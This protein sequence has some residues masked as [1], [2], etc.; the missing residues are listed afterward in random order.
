MNFIEELRTSEEF[1]RL[2]EAIQAGRL[3]PDNTA[4]AKDAND[5][6]IKNLLGEKLVFHYGYDR[7]LEDPTTEMILYK[8]GLVQ[9]LFDRRY[10]YTEK[11]GKIYANGLC[12]TEAY[13]KARLINAS[14]T[15]AGE[16]AHQKVYRQSDGATH[17]RVEVADTELASPIPL[18]LADSSSYYRKFDT[19]AA[20]QYKNDSNYSGV[21]VK[22]ERAQIM[23]SH[24]LSSFDISYF[25]D[26]ATDTYR[27]YGFSLHGSAAIIAESDKGC[28]YMA[29]E[30]D[31]KHY[32]I[33]VNC[34]DTNAHAFV[35]LNKS[36][37]GATKKIL[38]NQSQ[39]EMPKRLA[40]CIAQRI[41][42]GPDF[43][44][45]PEK[46]KKSASGF[47]MRSLPSP[48]K[49]LS[50]LGEHFFLQPTKNSI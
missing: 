9:L 21:S 42:L 15:H 47:T 50:F 14:T 13:I 23:I 43:L 24:R 49:K 38:W 22:N 41:S 35:I 25:I 17:V 32:F 10:L 37:N 7:I 26:E 3:R 1:R 46:E 20:V 4:Q 44:K 5:A 31:K 8:G 29:T 33:L 16:L 12:Q 19:S 30:E 45:I 18:E 6:T 28:I 48:T 39:D 36:D 34:P 27:I 2:G 40:E 11:D